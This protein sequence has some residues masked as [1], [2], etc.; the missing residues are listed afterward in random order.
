MQSG[1]ND[2]GNGGK[3]VAVVAMQGDFEKH[4]TMLR[5]LGADA[6]T[7]R[8]PAEVDS[9]DGVILP[10]GESTTIGKLLARYGVDEAIRNAAAQQKPI[11]GTCAGM[12]LLARG[13]AEGTG[14]RGGQPTLGLLDITVQRNAFGRQVDSFEADV[15]VPVVGVDPVHAVFIR[16]PIVVDAG[17]G[18]ETL[19][20]IDG[21]TVFVKQGSILGSSFHPE[22]TGDD[23][24]HRYFLSLIK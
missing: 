9:A 16:A 2:V 13:I 23:R 1:K 15:D 21:K 22:L 18:V 14:E 24:V 11:Y 20:T 12:I 10:G 6:F 3:R 17:V 19:A 8:T 4:V 7:A 5:T